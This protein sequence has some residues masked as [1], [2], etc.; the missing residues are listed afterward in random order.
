MK[1]LLILN[2]HISTC[3]SPY[4]NLITENF[5]NSDASSSSKS[6]LESTY[7]KA[8]LN[9]KE[10]AI[11]TND[12]NLLN[13]V[14]NY[15][16]NKA[17]TINKSAVIFNI[18]EQFYKKTK[19]EIAY[20]ILILDYCDSL[21]NLDSVKILR[22][23]KGEYDYLVS[24]SKGDFIK[25]SADG[26]IIDENKYIDM[27]LMETIK[28]VSQEINYYANYFIKSN[29]RNSNELEK[30]ISYLRKAY[31][32]YPDKE[33]Y[34]TAAKLHYLIH[35]KENNPFIELLENEREFQSLFTKYLNFI[36]GE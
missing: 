27:Y 11:A 35:G 17:S 24:R 14:L 25:K 1:T 23:L 36:K 33:Y 19:N 2:N 16:N 31:Q 26:T 6:L 20:K 4:F 13:K 18:Q 8:I 3:E 10:K 29:N 34:L 21:S 30:N 15:E 5:D 22:I 32:L 12:I 28:L 7:R 9:C